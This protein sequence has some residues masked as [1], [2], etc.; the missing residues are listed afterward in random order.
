MPLNPGIR[1]GPYE[2]KLALGPGGR[3]TSR[4]QG[5]A[6]RLGTTNGEEL[7][8]T[9]ERRRTKDAVSSVGPVAHRSEWALKKAGGSVEA[10]RLLRRTRGQSGTRIPHGLLHLQEMAPDRHIIGSVRDRGL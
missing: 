10:C 5:A 2:S 3:A 7:G 6:G 8:K 4:D 1:V 9:R